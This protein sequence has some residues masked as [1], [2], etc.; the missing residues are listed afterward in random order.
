MKILRGALAV[1]VGYAIFVASAL[2]L[3]KLIGIDP[4]AEPT[5]L[6]M[7]AVIVAAIFL[8]APMS[9]LGGVLR[10]RGKNKS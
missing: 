4:H 5:V 1:I 6:V 8:F 7:L 10:I 2:M 3:F 9:V